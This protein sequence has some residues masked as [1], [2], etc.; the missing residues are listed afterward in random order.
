MG[1]LINS[2]NSLENSGPLKAEPG[3]TLYANKRNIEKETLYKV[4]PLSLDTTS[5][6][7]P[8]Y[9]WFKK[10]SQKLNKLIEDLNPNLEKILSTGITEKGNQ[11]F[12]ESEPVDGLSL[13]ELMTQPYASILPAEEILKIAW[14]LSNSLAHIHAK[15]ILHGQVNSSTIRHH[16]K[17]GKYILT[18]LGLNLISP[19]NR[20]EQPFNEESGANDQ[21]SFR[22]DI[23]DY[24]ILLIRLLTGKI[25]VPEDVKLIKNADALTSL[26]LLLRKEKF[27][28]DW[29]KG[30]K[31]L[32]LNLPEWLFEF[33]AT[34][35]LLN[36]KGFANGIELKE[37]LGNHFKTSDLPIVSPET[38]LPAG[39]SPI[40]TAELQEKNQEITKLKALITQKEGQLNVYKYQSAEFSKKKQLV[41]SSPAFFSLLFLI[42]LLGSIAVYSLFF[43]KPGTISSLTAYADADSSSKISYSA[44]SK[45]IDSA[46]FVDSV[47]RTLNMGIDS[48]IQKYQKKNT[49]ENVEKPAVL[50]KSE[51]DRNSRNAKK[52]RN[53][54][55]QTNS[56]KKPKY[57]LIEP[58]EEEYVR[59]I[60]YSVAVPK[61]YFYEQPD[62]RT[63][64]PLYLSADTGS[65]E[66]TASQDS[67]GFIYVVFFNTEG[68]ITKGWLRKQDLRV[69][70]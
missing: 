53:N 43:S 23:Y 60:K 8:D 62:V 37:F 24:G 57:E 48:V 17:S 51:P 40:S 21:N 64:K 33:I 3:G 12:V 47:N 39:V 2:I 56:N 18:G 25:I 13:E 41:L 58:A 14:Q 68:E 66:L 5:A 30:R 22:A 44:S 70:Y 20:P 54:S 35:L 11:P 6:D 63:K 19:Q 9:K 38:E 67:N 52:E 16:L 45:Q 50:E 65:T 49:V 46:A 27:P 31:D 28:A 69:S 61:A 36:N 1:N 34:C 59:N 55:N 42:L 4:F 32:E 26:I 15:N 7:D 10:E 29:D